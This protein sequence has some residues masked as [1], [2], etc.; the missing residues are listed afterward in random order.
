M[1][2]VSV[3][4]EEERKDE[5]SLKQSFEDSGKVIIEL[6]L[7]KTS[8]KDIQ[9]RLKLTID[10]L[11]SL[12]RDVSTLGLF[13]DNESMEEL[14]TSSLQFM[15]IPCYLGIAQHNLMTEPL[16]REEQLKM[17]KVYYMDFLK[18][19]YDYNV[20]TFKLP[21]KGEEQDDDVSDLGLKAIER[22]SGDEL[23][24][25]KIVRFKQQKELQTAMDR[26]KIEQERNPDDESTLREFVIVQLRYWSLRA[27]AELHSIEDELPILEHM[28]KLYSGEVQ[29]EHTKPRPPSQKPFIIA[30][31]QEQKKVFGI[32]YPAIPTMTVD[33]WFE[34]M[35]SS[36]RWGQAGAPGQT[37][38]YAHRGHNHGEDEECSEKHPTTEAD[39]SD[40]DK[41]DEVD[42]EMLRQKQMRWDEYKDTHRRGWGNMH[43]KG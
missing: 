17:A 34:G 41:E 24:Q 2:L 28:K 6:E 3:G 29:S 1:S 42:P 11:E 16:M 27:L 30:R 25:E 26:F 18:R 39:L 37:P 20:I 22:K 12:T 13:S 35:A 19:L 5:E 4:V 7:G 15:L 23:R 32:G 21:W 43:N 9:H 31:S 38:Q 14:P 10:H 40:S 8:T 36:G 33:E